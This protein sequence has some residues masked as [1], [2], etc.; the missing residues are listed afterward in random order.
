VN[1]GIGLWLTLRQGAGAGV[2]TPS[3]DFSDARNSMYL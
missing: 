1:L 2:F 3:L